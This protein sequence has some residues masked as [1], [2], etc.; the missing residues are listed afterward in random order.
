MTLRSLIAAAAIAALLAG[1]AG[2]QLGRN[3][4]GFD[5]FYKKFR[6]QVAAQGINPQLLD[7]SFSGTPAPLP[8]V[9]DH[10]Q[11]QPEV[12]QTFAGYLRIML[13]ETRRQ[14]GEA[15][16]HQY[17]AE[18][19]RI[20]SQTGVPAE[21]IVALWGIES[22]Y[23][24]GMGGYPTIPALTTL[25]WASKRGD[26]FGREAVNALK[27]AQ[28][29]GFPPSRLTGSWAGAMGGCQFMPSTYLKYAKDGD[30]DGKADIWS[31]PL[32]VFA[33]TANYLHSL[34][35]K[36][37]QPWRIRAQVSVELPED[38]KF[39][40]RGLS[41]RQTIAQWQKWGVVSRGGSFAAFGGTGTLTRIYR[42]MG[43]D[44]PTYMLGP[45]VDAVLGWNNSSYFAASVFLLAESIRTG[46]L[47]DVE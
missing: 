44:G 34:G 33:S 38:A 42:P 8:G 43:A 29:E 47:P 10:E 40:E 27:V 4:D 21:V 2:Q 12:K 15:M 30:G 5:A 17:D 16:L 37:G 39:N 14:K 11:N 45:N 28:Q 35:W 19:S 18:L 6:A 46:Q 7:Q 9:L 25:A 3:N 31:N 26:F 23:G 13:S 36:A 1:C 24:A 22:N 41:S 32:D 20:S